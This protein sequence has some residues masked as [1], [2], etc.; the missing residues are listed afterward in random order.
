MGLRLTC[1]TRSAFIARR[2]CRPEASRH[3]TMTTTTSTH[4][5][6]TT[7]FTITTTTGGVPLGKALS[8]T[9]KGSDGRSRKRNRSPS[10]PHAFRPADMPSASAKLS[11][12]WATMG[13]AAL[14]GGC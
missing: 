11:A 12:M 1:A 2:V 9:S 14:G 3:S 6:P 7:T 10:T 13:A 4:I 5:P 8:A